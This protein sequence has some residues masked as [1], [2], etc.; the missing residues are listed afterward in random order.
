MDGLS[1]CC[2]STAFY[3]GFLWRA[4]NWV[5]SQAAACGSDQKWWFLKTELRVV[6]EHKRG[7]VWEVMGRESHWLEGL[8]WEN[9]HLY[10]QGRLWVYLNQMQIIGL[11][12]SCPAELF[13]SNSLSLKQSPWTRHWVENQLWHQTSACSSFWWIKIVVW[14]AP[15]IKWKQLRKLPIVWLRGWWKSQAD[16]WMGRAAVSISQTLILR[17]GFGSAAL[18]SSLGREHGKKRNPTLGPWSR[19]SKFTFFSF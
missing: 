13:M 17:A 12:C 9:S 2:F 3:W 14:V 8:I 16:G 19:S 6:I 5:F 18:T 15:L 4:L 10:K 11:F 1:P 7:W